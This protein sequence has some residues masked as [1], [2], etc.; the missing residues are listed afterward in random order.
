MMGTK[1]VLQCFHPS[2]KY[3]LLIDKRSWNLGKFSFEYPRSVHTCC[4]LFK[5]E[6]VIVHPIF[7]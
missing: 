2:C 7:D 4:F 6:P 5:Q 3:K 1:L